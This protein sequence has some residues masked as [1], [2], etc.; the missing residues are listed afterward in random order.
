MNDLA[1]YRIYVSWLWSL[2]HH[3]APVTKDGHLLRQ[4]L[5]ADGVVLGK[6]AEAVKAGT[7]LDRALF[8]KVFA[9]HD[10]WTAAFFAEQDR[11]GAPGRFDRSKAPVIMDLLRRQL[12]SP[13]Y[14]Q[15]SARVLFVI[16]QARPALH[17]QILE[18]IFDLSREEVVRR[19][20][21]GRMDRAALEAHDY[22]LDILEA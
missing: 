15:H 6:Q 18:A 9:Y 20:Q 7:R 11:S 14:V 2:A 22:C 10:E 19:V 8:D 17:G 16:G 12:L 1:T 13:R 21:A 5:T 3:Q 4:E